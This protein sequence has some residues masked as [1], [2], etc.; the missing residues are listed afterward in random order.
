MASTVLEVVEVA[1]EVVL[2]AQWVRE[3][4][5]MVLEA[6]EVVQEVDLMDQWV[7][8]VNHLLDLEDLEV[9]LMVLE[10][11][12]VI[13]TVLEAAEVDQEVDQEAVLMVQCAREVQDQM[14][15]LRT[16]SMVFSSLVDQEAQ[17]V[18]LVVQE[19]RGV[20]SVVQEAASE[21]DST[22]EGECR[23]DQEAHQEAHPDPLL[24]LLKRLSLSRLPDPSVPRQKTPGTKPSESHP[25]A[26]V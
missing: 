6:V 7:Q 4:L 19:A 25:A 23:L 5:S 8:E 1:Q 13:S 11:Q 10:D 22:V 21:V 15:S 14:I 18:V 20:A 2:M 26:K 3:V 17:E 9:D 12:E 16:I 24:R